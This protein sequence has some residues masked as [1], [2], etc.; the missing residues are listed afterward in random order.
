MLKGKIKYVIIAVCV[1]V[2]LAG[3]ITTLCFIPAI[4]VA[5]NAGKYDFESYAE[6][7]HGDRIHFLSTG[8]SDAILIESDG[9]YALVDCAEDNDNPRGFSGLQLKGYE[10][11]VLSYVKKIAGDKDG[12][13]TLEFVLGT[14]SHS[15]H[16]GGFDTLIMDK[17]INVK[18]AYMKEYDASKINDHEVTEWDNQEVYDQFMNACKTRGVP[19]EHNL[20]NVVERFGNF[21]MKIMNGEVDTSNEKKGENENS[22]GLLVSAFGKK[23]FLSGDINNYDG[24]ED[25]LGDLIGDIDMLKAGHHGYTGS[26]SKDYVKKLNPEIVVLTNTIHG[27]N[28][29][30]RKSVN[31]V[32]AAVYATKEHNGIIAEFSANGIKLYDNIH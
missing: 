32:D 14:H 4:K 6:G 30:V 26:S 22:I 29:S 8:G 5:V 27:M 16:I 7:S 18:K 24:D 1:A 2:L 12:K 13:V 28:N 23:A 11:V 19:V 10:D 15:D 3:I 31:A 20:V 17:D 21:E 9:K 25:R